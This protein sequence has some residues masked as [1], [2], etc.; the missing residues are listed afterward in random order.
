MLNMLMLQS[1]Y[2]KYVIVYA[3]AYMWLDLHQNIA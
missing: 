2:Y 1:E 3:T